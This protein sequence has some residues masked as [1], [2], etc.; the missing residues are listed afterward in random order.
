MKLRGLAAAGLAA[1][2]SAGAGLP[3]V[4]GQPAV[5]TVNGEPV[6]L[7]EMMERL[8]SLHQEAAD[9]A[10]APAH[11][12]PMLVLQRIIDARLVV[13]EARSIGLDQQPEVIDRL[14]AARLAL[15]KSGVA[16]NAVK[17]VTAADPADVE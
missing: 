16:R 1:A 8:G 12:D 9:P 5:A 4:K 15:L 11:P 6:T 10:A 14:A 2:L 7:A 3:T 17:N 13:Q